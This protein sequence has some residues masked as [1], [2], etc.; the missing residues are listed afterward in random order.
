[1][2]LVASV[3]PIRVDGMMPCSDATVVMFAP[4]TG[5]DPKKMCAP[6]PVP[7]VASESTMVVEFVT[8]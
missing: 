2:A 8:V 3:G 7:V 1:M 6:V 4:V 5:A